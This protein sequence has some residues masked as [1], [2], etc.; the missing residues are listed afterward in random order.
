MAGIEAIGDFTQGGL[1]ARAAEPRTGEASEGHTHEASCLN[2]GCALTG[3]FCHCCGQHAHVHRTIGAFFHDLAHG[4]L[5]FEGKTWRTLPLLAWNPGELTRQYIGGRRASYVSPIALFL[6]SVFLMFAAVNATGGGSPHLAEAQDLAAQQRDIEEKI[7]KL[8][9]RRAFVGD[10]KE[11]A[12]DIAEKIKDEQDDLQV[13]RVLRSQGVAQETFSREPVS[14][15]SAAPWVR[16]ALTKAKDNPELLLYKMKSNSYKWSWAIIP[17]SVPF[18]WLMFPFNRRFHI[19]D[20]VVFVTYSL[21]FM[22]LMIAMGTL[23]AVAGIPQVAAIMPFIPP[24]HM[25]RQLR[26]AY[27]VSPFGAL[28]RTF[29]LLVAAALVLTAFALM[30]LGLGLMH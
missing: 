25:Y 3:E 4:V 26:G 22:T 2:C 21:S 30:M 5:H 7:A 14:A 13:I 8:E 28:W 1:I 12:N 24:L 11:A 23:L 15:Q 27:S 6:F 10:N 9:E 18:L 16:E 17:L 29:G 20:H 19:Y